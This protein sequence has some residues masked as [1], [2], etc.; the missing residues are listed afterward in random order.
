M[1]AIGDFFSLPVILGFIAAIV[2]LIGLA[3]LIKIGMGKDGKET[4][5]L[6]R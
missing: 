5:T 2:F 4:G 3:A 1:S 6:A